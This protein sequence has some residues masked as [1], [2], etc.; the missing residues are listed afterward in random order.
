LDFFPD[1]LYS[2]KTV[3]YSGSHFVYLPKNYKPWNKQ[4]LL[5]TRPQQP[6]N[7]AVTG[8]ELGQVAFP[9]YYVETRDT[10][11]KTLSRTVAHNAFSSSTE[12]FPEQP[13]QPI[14]RVNLPKAKGAFTVITP[15]PLHT[16]HV[17]VVQIAPGKNG[18][19]TLSAQTTSPAENAAT[20]RELASFKITL[21]K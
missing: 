20:V 15:V 3:Y 16:D 2:L 11:G 19:S 9:G 4:C 17:S 12:V 14:T 18:Q 10:K 13:G 6:V 5:T 8:A 21:N 7:M 1:S